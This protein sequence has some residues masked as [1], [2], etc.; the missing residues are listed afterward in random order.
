MGTIDKLKNVKSTN[1]LRIFEQQQSF[2]KTK[3]GEFKIRSIDNDIESK[4]I[5]VGT[6]LTA[7]YFSVGQKL[8]LKV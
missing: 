4:L 1:D 7:D 6:E 3:I 2:T 5:P 8:T